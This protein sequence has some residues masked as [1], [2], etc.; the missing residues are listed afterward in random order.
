MTLAENVYALISQVPKG[1]VTTYKS[2][3]E[4]LGMKG[5]QAIGQVLRCNPN[6]PTVPC[7]RV[8][9]SSG[10][11]GGFKGEVSGKEIEEKVLLLRSE[12][13]IVV[14]GRIDLAKFGF[15]W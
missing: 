7:H 3:A 11:I 5:Y 15:R 6:A 13:V 14:D 12:G 8:I 4:K 9:S 2:I 10:S 1:K